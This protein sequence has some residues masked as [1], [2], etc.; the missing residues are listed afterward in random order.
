MLF[1]G[2]IA[3]N[4]QW[5]FSA[6]ASS[7]VSTMLVDGQRWMVAGPNFDYTT[8]GRLMTYFSNS[9]GPAGINHGHYHYY[10]AFIPYSQAF[11]SFA[12]PTLKGQLTPLAVLFAGI[13]SSSWVRTV[14]PNAPLIAE[15]AQQL[16]TGGV[17]S[18]IGHRHYWNSDYSVLRRGDRNLALA[19]SSKG[20][21]ASVRMVSTRTLDTEC[22]NGEGLQGENLADGVTNVYVT[23]REFEN[24]FPVWNWRLLPGTIEV[25]KPNPTPLN[26]VDIYRD[27][28]RG[29]RHSF[30]GGVSDGSIGCAVMDYRP[31]GR[32]HLHR[33][34]FMLDRVVVVANIGIF[35]QN[36]SFCLSLCL[37]RSVSV[38]PPACLPAC[39]PVRLSQ[40]MYLG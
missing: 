15:F 8:C 29:K 11:P 10:A 22:G 18:A 35:V 36:L 39:L 13:L 37:C 32:V 23:G 21:M 31:R 16:R 9:S 5:E 26:C 40:S 3:V 6:T 33:S 14:I 25:Q 34:W 30:V 1:F 28:A 20:F 2:S 27:P 24:V 19:S 12:S 17:S 7:G 38:C 4:T